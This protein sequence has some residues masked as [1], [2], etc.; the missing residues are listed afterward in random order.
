MG[1]ADKLKL[2]RNALNLKQEDLSQRV[3]V[4]RRSINSYENE[5]VIP[6]GKVMRSL[7]QALDVSVAYLT[8]DSIHDINHGK[9]REA[10]IEAARQRFGPSAVREAERLLDEN[11]AFFA[12]GD[13]PQE[14]KDAF[15]DAVM[16]AYLACKET[17]RLKQ[18]RAG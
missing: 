1:F 5:G 7:A 3:G 15:F 13:M 4:S 16:G 12:G 9:A 2:A 10:Q 6:R 11:T 18:S 17:A 14:D 8:D